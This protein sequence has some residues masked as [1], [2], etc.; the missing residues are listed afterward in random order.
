MYSET[1]L[2]VVL[3]FNIQLSYDSY[4]ALSAAGARGGNTSHSARR[5]PEWEVPNATRHDA[6]RP[7]SI[8]VA[9]AV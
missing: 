8:S 2:V 5:V 9:V 3:V 6:T 1:A 7:R 4:A